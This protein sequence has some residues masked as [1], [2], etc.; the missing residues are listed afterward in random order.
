MGTKGRGDKGQVVAA[1][2]IDVVVYLFA[3]MCL[4]ICLFVLCVSLF[5]CLFVCRWFGRGKRESGEVLLLLTVVILAPAPAPRRVCVALP[6]QVAALAAQLQREAVVVDL[7]AAAAD[8]HPSLHAVGWVL[9][10]LVADVGNA[11]GG[12]DTVC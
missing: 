12:P 8:Q 2:E 11:A 6:A 1:L 9:H 10:P 3:Y 5:V 4:H 7:L